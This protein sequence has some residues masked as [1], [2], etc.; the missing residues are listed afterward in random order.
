MVIVIDFENLKQTKSLGCG[1]IFEGLGANSI[2]K[3]DDG[4]LE[5]CHLRP[6]SQLTKDETKAL[7]DTL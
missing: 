1:N 5:S 2:P 6:P 7:L 3:T 4:N